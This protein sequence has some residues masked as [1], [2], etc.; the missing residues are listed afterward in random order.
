MTASTVLRRE[1]RVRMDG[2]CARPGCG[3]L[4]HP[5]RSRR[6]AKDEALRDP[7]CSTECCKR[8]FKVRAAS[9]NDETPQSQLA[10]DQ[11]E[12]DAELEAGG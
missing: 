4:R 11:F 8:F 6:Y 3:K 9:G 10:R 2:R 12:F 7:F 5:E 1:P